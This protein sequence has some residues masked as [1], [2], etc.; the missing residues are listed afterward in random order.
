MHV[1]IG[2][3]GSGGLP[4]FRL[5]VRAKGWGLRPLTPFGPIFGGSIEIVSGMEIF[6]LIKFCRLARKAQGSALQPAS[7]ST[8]DL[9]QGSA[10]DPLVSRAV[11]L[12]KDNVDS[13]I[14]AV[15]W[16]SVA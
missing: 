14:I 3:W 2:P 13:T 8:L 12:V 15:G 7:V 11:S 5:A 9:D 6:V 1:K 4:P 10:L 16:I